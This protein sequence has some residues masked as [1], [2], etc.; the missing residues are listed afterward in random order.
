MSRFEWMVALRYLRAKRKQAVISII[1]VI[2]ILGVGAGVAALIIALAVNNGFQNTLQSSL[3]SATAHVSILEANP[4]FGI[5]D[6]EALLPKLRR[7]PHVIAVNPVL[8]GQIALKGPLA[9]AGAVLKGVALGRGAPAP[10]LL[11]HLKSGSLTPFDEQD[12][13]HQ[14]VLGS[15]LAQAAGVRLHSPVTVI[16]YQGQLTPLGPVPTLFHFRVA[17]IFESGLY[18]LDSTWAFTT[19]Q[20]AQR[21]FDLS[22]VVNS[23]EIRLDNIFVAREVARQANAIIGQKLVASTW[24]DQN[25][26]LLDALKLEKTVSVITVAL[27]ELVAA[28]NILVVLVMLVMEK[29]RDVAILIAMGARRQ[30]IQRIFVLQGLIIG[31]VGSAIGLI[32]GYSAAGL[33]N[34]YRWLRLDEQV[35]AISYVPFQS[36]WTDAIWVASLALLTSLVATLYPSHAAAAVAP[37]EALRYE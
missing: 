30:Q 19:L 24:M 13:G 23:I 20:S 8:Y 12:A 37:A 7:L 5:Q 22:D 27:I 31:A 1:T 29:H 3:L 17:A 10:D 25:H 18:D 36:H 35:Y 32:A 28:L 34:H 16:S 33:L 11:Q 4:E 6:W 15:R 14:I 21:V 2:S 26:S 9:G